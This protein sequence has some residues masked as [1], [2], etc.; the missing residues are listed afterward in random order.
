MEGVQMLQRLLVSTTSTSKG[1]YQHHSSTSKDCYQHHI[2]SCEGASN[3]I[4]NITEGSY[5]SALP[6]IT[7]KKESLLEHPN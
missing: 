2:N 5:V 7:R 4:T 6:E 3:T 1:C